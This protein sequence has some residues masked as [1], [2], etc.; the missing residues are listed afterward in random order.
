MLLLIRADRHQ[1]RLVQ[2]N[3][4]RHQNRIREQ[5]AVDIVRVLGGFVLELRH[6]RKLAHISK[7]IEQPRQLRVLRHL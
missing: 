6:A 7:A 3:I 5:T 1:I 4:R 2:E